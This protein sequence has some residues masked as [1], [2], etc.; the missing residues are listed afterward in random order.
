MRTTTTKLLALGTAAALG[1]A[2]CGG[3]EEESTVAV[4][5][6]ARPVQQG[7]AA[8]AEPEPAPEATQVESTVDDPASTLRADLTLLLQE[9]VHLTGLAVA[10]IADGGE[11][12]PVTQG[13][14]QALDDNAMALGAVIGAT[15][16]AEDVEA[17][18]EGWREHI[19]AYVDY[20]AARTEGDDE[21][22]TEATATLEALLEPMADFFEAISEEEISADEIVGELET[23]V[24]MVSD[25]IDAAVAQDEAAPDLLDEAA[26]HMDTLA[27]ELATGIVAA[28]PEDLPGD[29]LSVP[30]ETRAGLVSG[31]VEHTYLTLL[32]AG[33]TVAAGGA[34]DD[35]AVQAAST[36]LEGSADGLANGVSGA[37]GNEGR[38]AFLD[39]WRPFLTAAADYAAASASGDAAGAEAARTTMLDA[40]AGLAPV[41][42][43]STAGNAPDDL[44]ALLDTHVTNLLGAIDA[45]VAGDPAATA[46][47]RAAAQHASTIAT[48]VARG[49]AAV[50]PEEP[51]SGGVDADDV[52]ADPNTAAPDQTGDDTSDAGISDE[53]SG[54]GD[55][56]PA[57]AGDG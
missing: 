51:A 42:E 49:L 54:G 30:A 38:E 24:T 33:K 6:K 56:G 57:A 1:L 26:H 46:Q 19:A 48:G 44:P 18:V 52:N 50:S 27:T 8:P 16:G 2:A 10:G 31:F 55:T 37:G 4:S 23:H 34:A 53:G 43:Q 13:A 21:A 32:A 41:L 47:A 11:D 15:P 28:F 25:A 20:A 3:G 35:P 22:A 12:G 29:P 39:L 17:F 45:M 9:H 36:T 7:A 40:P 5:G 14:V